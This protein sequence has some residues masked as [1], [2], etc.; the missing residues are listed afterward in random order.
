MQIFISSKVINNRSAF[1]DRLSLSLSVQVFE[2]NK[3]S[4]AKR[5]YK[6]FCCLLLAA[7]GVHQFIN[8]C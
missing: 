8:L 5:S 6:S 4:T 2:K 3:I 7:D 1:L